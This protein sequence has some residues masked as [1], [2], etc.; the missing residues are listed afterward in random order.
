MLCCEGSTAVENTLPVLGITL[1]ALWRLATG[2]E[3]IDEE[4]LWRAK[5]QLRRQH[6]LPAGGD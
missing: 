5:T 2:M 1:T 6:L 4:E 3:P